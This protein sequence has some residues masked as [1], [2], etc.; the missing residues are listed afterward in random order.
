[1]ITES[2]RIGYNAMSVLRAQWCVSKLDPPRSA[3]SK[4]YRAMADSHRMLMHVLTK[5]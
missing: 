3:I 2:R 5:S 4:W 1:M